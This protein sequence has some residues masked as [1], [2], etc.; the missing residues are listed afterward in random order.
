MTSSR[1][2]WRRR[3]PHG[4]KAI[5][6]R[7]WAV[8]EQPRSASL[9]DGVVIKGWREALKRYQSQY[10]TAADMG[11]LSTSDPDVKTVTDD[12]AIVTGR[13]AVTAP[14]G[15][16]TGTFSLVMKQFDGRWRIVHDTSTSDAP[17]ANWLIC[18]LD[19]GLRRGERFEC[20]G[21]YSQRQAHP[22]RKSGST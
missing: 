20:V 1:A 16:G 5:S 22:G 7:S 11:Q 4:T 14:S 21:L 3:P 6:P 17:P 2:C 8:L 13:Y 12:V 10:P 19:P 15:V 18:E 9:S